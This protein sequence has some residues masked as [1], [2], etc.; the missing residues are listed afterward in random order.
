MSGKTVNQAPHQPGG[1]R[2]M[3]RRADA[4][5]ARPRDHLAHVEM[6]VLAAL[7]ERAVE[8]P[9]ARSRR[10]AAT[11]QCARAAPDR[12]AR[13]ACA[14]R[15]LQSRCSSRRHDRDDETLRGAFKAEPAARQ[16]H[17]GAPARTGAPRYFVGVWRHSGLSVAH[18]RHPVARDARV[19]GPGREIVREVREGRWPVRAVERRVL[20]STNGPAISL[21][22]LVRSPAA[23]RARSLPSAGAHRRRRSPRPA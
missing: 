14:R 11:R 2:R 20:T 18:D 16:R 9:R 22:R 6:H 4:G 10:S 15:A 13:R 7:G 17:F 5:V 8:R 1:E 23:I 3:L 21:Q 12:S 19:V